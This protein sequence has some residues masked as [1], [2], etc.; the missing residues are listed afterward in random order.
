MGVTSTATALSTP[1]R[2]SHAAAAA[3]CAAATV[4]QRWQLAASS[5]FSFGRTVLFC[6]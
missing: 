3:S 1:T 2:G 5:I 6:V 4:H